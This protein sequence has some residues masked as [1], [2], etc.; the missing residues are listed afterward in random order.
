[1]DLTKFSK[2]NKGLLSQKKEQQQEI[3]VGRPKIKKEEDKLDKK[4]TVN[5]NSYEKEFLEDLNKK[6]GI[7][8]STY[9]RKKLLEADAFKK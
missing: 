7:P 9:L 3:R 1:M 8:I 2:D 5:I 4:I 6:T